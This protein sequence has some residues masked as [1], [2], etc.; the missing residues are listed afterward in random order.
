M[1]SP[2]ELVP[3]SPTKPGATSSSEDEGEDDVSLC[4]PAVP[5]G[6]EPRGRTDDP[7]K[8]ILSAY[9]T[10]MGKRKNWRKRWFVLTSESLM[11]SSSHMVRAATA[12]LRDQVVDFNSP[13]P[14]R[15]RNP[16]G[17]FQWRGS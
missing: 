11:Y 6:G 12:F 8:V 4:A 16:T 2:S 3:G 14:C 13:F 9:L 10:K 5:A 7:T 17:S 1:L 15:T